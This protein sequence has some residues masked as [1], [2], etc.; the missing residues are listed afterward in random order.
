METKKIYNM[1]KGN[2]QTLTA[3]NEA[4]DRFMVLYGKH[5]HQEHYDNQTVEYYDGELFINGTRQGLELIS[6]GQF[7]RRYPVFVKATSRKE[8]FI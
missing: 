4:G 8:I 5:E 6:L 2:W 7:F 3:S 1:V